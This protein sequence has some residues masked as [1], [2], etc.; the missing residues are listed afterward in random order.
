MLKMPHSPGIW[1]RRGLSEAAPCVSQIEEESSEKRVRMEEGQGKV[2]GK[3][4]MS[5]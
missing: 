1:E 4:A 3:T 2:W 5:A